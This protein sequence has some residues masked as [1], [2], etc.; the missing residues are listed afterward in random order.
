MFDSVG[1]GEFD[2]HFYERF[3]RFFTLFFY[4]V[5][6]LFIFG[7]QSPKTWETK[8]LDPNME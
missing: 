7:H 3:Y 4:R 8:V 1:T 5:I 6:L 2:L